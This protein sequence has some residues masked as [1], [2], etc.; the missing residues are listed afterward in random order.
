MWNKREDKR[1][2]I[3]TFTDYFISDAATSSKSAKK[4]KKKRSK[5]KP[6]GSGGDSE[7]QADLQDVLLELKEQL[8]IAKTTKV[9]IH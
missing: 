7:Q 6:C 1:C 3:D 2:R 5:N 4:N 8:E 9:K